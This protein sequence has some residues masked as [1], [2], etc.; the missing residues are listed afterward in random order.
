MNKQLVG[1]DDG[2]TQVTR[3]GDAFLFRTIRNPHT[4]GRGHT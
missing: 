3:R 4:I 1:H 2:D